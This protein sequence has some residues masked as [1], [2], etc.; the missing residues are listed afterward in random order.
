MSGSARECCRWYNASIKG[1]KRSLRFAESGNSVERAGG[2]SR[3]E[4][5]ERAVRYSKFALGN[6]SR[7]PSPRL[8]ASPLRPPSLWTHI[9]CAFA[10]TSTPL[11]APTHPPT[12]SVCFQ[13]QMGRVKRPRRR[14]RCGRPATAATAPPHARVHHADGLLAC[15]TPALWLAARCHPIRC[16]AQCCCPTYTSMESAAAHSSTRRRQRASGWP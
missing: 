15:R 14:M 3:S 5:V 4:Q 9:F 1:K 10:S 16:S 7:L 11:R 8:G 6:M 12:H 13:N 2:T